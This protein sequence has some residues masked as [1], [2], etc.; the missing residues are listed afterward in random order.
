MWCSG[1]LFAF[2][3]A[4]IAKHVM[5]P[6]RVRLH[7]QTHAG[8]TPFSPPLVSLSDCKY[9]HLLCGCLLYS[10]LQVHFL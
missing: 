4:A 8:E 1:D 3:D 2:T 5:L 10:I 9:V 7:E 6:K